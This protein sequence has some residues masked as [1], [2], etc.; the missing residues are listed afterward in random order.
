MG[1]RDTL[2]DVYN[3]SREKDLVR[4]S[5]GVDQINSLLGE[6]DILGRLTEVLSDVTDYPSTFVP[7]EFTESVLTNPSL[8]SFS[9]L[10]LDAYVERSSTPE[11]RAARENN[12]RI[13]Y[14]RI[15]KETAMGSFYR[16]DKI[17]V[18][19][20]GAM[21]PAFRDLL[22]IRRLAY[23]F[24]RDYRLSHDI[25]FTEG[26]KGEISSISSDDSVIAK[27]WEVLIETAISQWDGRTGLYTSI[28][29]EVMMYI[30]DDPYERWSY[31]KGLLTLGRGLAFTKTTEGV[32]RRWIMIR[33]PENKDS[34]GVLTG[35]G[36]QPVEVV[37][38][39]HPP[40]G[41]D[42]SKGLA[43]GLWDVTGEK[44]LET[45][46]EVG[47]V[48][49][50]YAAA[51]VSLVAAPATNANL[52]L[53]QILN[54]VHMSIG[55]VKTDNVLTAVKQL[56]VPSD[57]APPAATLEVESRDFGITADIH[58]HGVTRYYMVNGKP[59]V[60]RDR[61]KCDVCFPC[62]LVSVWDEMCTESLDIK[63]MMSPSEYR[64]ALGNH[65][66]SKA[67][68]TVTPVFATVNLGL[69]S[70]G[71]RIQR[72]LRVHSKQL[73]YLQTIDTIAERGSYEY[74][75]AN[76][77][78]KLT[79]RA[80]RAR[81]GR[82]VCPTPVP[83][84]G[85]EIP[86]GEMIQMIQGFRPEFS[87]KRM[88]ERHFSNHS[89]MAAASASLGRFINFGWDATQMDKHSTCETIRWPMIQG[90][91]EAMER[92]G[93]VPPDWDDW[94]CAEVTAEHTDENM[95]TTSTERIF[96]GMC[97]RLWGIYSQVYN[98]RY[99]AESPT[100]F[101]LFVLNQVISGE[102]NTTAIHNGTG[103]AIA[104]IMMAM[105]RDIFTQVRASGVALPQPIMVFL[106]LTGD[107]AIAVMDN[108]EFSIMTKEMV[109]TYHTLLSEVQKM[110]GIPFNL[111]KLVLSPVSGEYL[112]KY[113]VFGCYVGL[114][115]RLQMVTSENG[116]FDADLPDVI[117]TLQSRGRELV[118]RGSDPERIALLK[119]WLAAL[120]LRIKWKSHT[121]SQKTAG[122]NKIR[123]GKFADEG[124]T[125]PSKALMAPL[126]NGGSS[127]HPFNIYVDGR[128]GL[129]LCVL[130]PSEKKWLYDK[131]VDYSQLTKPVLEMIDPFE[132]IEG[133][134]DKAKIMRSLMDERRKKNS[135]IAEGMLLRD[136]KYVVP[137]QV[138]Y[139]NSVDETIRRNV[140]E[141]KEIRSVRKDMRARRGVEFKRKPPPGSYYKG[142]K[143]EWMDLI[144]K[145]WGEEIP[146][147]AESALTTVV[148][149]KGTFKSIIDRYGSS[150]G[151]PRKINPFAV[152]SR[153]V[154]FRFPKHLQAE[155]ILQLVARSSDPSDRQFLTLLF[156]AIG[157]TPERA[158][159]AATAL[160]RM[161][162]SPLELEAI[163]GWSFSDSI[164]SVLDL[165]LQRTKSVVS[166]V[167][168]TGVS[169]LPL[170]IERAV[171]DF[172]VQ[173][174]IARAGMDGEVRKL[175]LRVS[176][177]VIKLMKARGMFRKGS[178][179]E[180]VMEA[181]VDSDPTNVPN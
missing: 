11:I 178:T 89:A 20:R 174:I 8:P 97:H 138:L 17:L 63:P 143:F 42:L 14:E 128:D 164:M 140:P 86:T 121:R 6:T 87:T 82:A 120:R 33:D 169:K 22:P 46:R 31:V 5:E 99:S 28:S 29:N 78:Q 154:D 41:A 123:V 172:G 152:I 23:L 118:T 110:T 107:D 59:M 101:M 124:V 112:K 21:G 160:A 73:A 155:T 25:P 162:V 150:P 108:S 38:M 18:A 49:P 37:D 125:L 173:M 30:S 47:K 83:F 16:V 62:Q 75:L 80:D 43:P 12:R 52:E 151:R 66:N 26:I 127:W 106:S 145:K 4:F 53:F 64:V 19:L 109:Q 171:Y 104:R 147:L 98:V 39:S 85:A 90:M 131:P 68:S 146:L 158:S 65:M 175:T 45:A 2:E 88:D 76:N 61:C 81:D 122:K 79:F 91:I 130:S 93:G 34:E 1:I 13:V 170:S 115:M 153:M 24:R 60:F 177:A 15:S 69:D 139:I 181:M 58:P 40:V 114:A 105:L 111:L 133:L 103:L 57:A 144:E 156:V 134:E 54:S 132:M 36:G 137:K 84:Y 32:F 9:L 119:F 168:E 126:I 35:T 95:R 100:G 136:Y 179:M 72:E 96:K 74:A 27:K 50:Q 176:K 161:E 102:F 7:P 180:K 167:Y 67:A 44:F 70:D 3:L 48:L 165:G 141:I 163:Q 92:H 51:W 56:G 135:A 55:Y 142:T 159:Q 94:S 10:S 148:G 166:V 117:S 113:F 71:K 116:M 149:V 129:M 157:A 77:I